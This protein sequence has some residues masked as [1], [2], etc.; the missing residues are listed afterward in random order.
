M[1]EGKGEDYVLKHKAKD[2]ILQEKNILQLV[3]SGGIDDVLPLLDAPD[4]STAVSY[5]DAVQS[6]V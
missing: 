6:L 3:L 2:S 4:A 1:G 5:R